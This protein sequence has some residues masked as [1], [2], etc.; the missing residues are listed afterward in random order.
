MSPGFII[1]G[2][3]VFQQK[4]G[5]TGIN[6]SPVRMRVSSNGLP[7]RFAFL[8]TNA[9]LAERNM[10]FEINFNSDVSVN[11]SNQSL[12]TTAVPSNLIYNILSQSAAPASSSYIYNLLSVC[13]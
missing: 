9:L 12:L 8:T 7:R 10:D 2:I 11:S 3:C 5:I 1:N 4:I 13:Y 6:L